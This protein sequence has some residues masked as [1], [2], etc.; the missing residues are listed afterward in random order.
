MISSCSTFIVD[1]H[2]YNS[3]VSEYVALV[4]PLLIM[5]VE[6]FKILQIEIKK[7]WMLL[8]LFNTFCPQ[9]LQ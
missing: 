3:K 1:K 9:I 6:M 4:L 8:S 2:V 7:T 5:Q